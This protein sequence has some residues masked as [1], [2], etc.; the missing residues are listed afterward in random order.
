MPTPKKP[1]AKKS[2]AKKGPEPKKTTSS[3]T[4]NLGAGLKGTK[5][6][7]DSMMMSRG[8]TPSINDTYLRPK[9]KSEVAANRAAAA[10]SNPAKTGKSPRK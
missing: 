4:Y 2:A 8:Y 3:K 9:S 1:V 7:Q 10:K 5:A 6:Q